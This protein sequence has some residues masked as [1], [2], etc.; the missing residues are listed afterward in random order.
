MKYEDRYQQY[1]RNN[2]IK[3]EAGIDFEKNYFIHLKVPSESKGKEIFYDV[4]V[5][6]F[7]PDEKI[8]KEITVE[9]YYV[10]FFS[11]SPGFIYKYA[12]LYKLQGYLIEFLTD[13]FV[14][15]ALD[16]LPDKANKTYD[17]YFDSTI[18]FACRYLLDHKATTLGKF[19]IRLMKTK[20]LNTFFQDIQDTDSI[21]TVREI[22]NLEASIRKEIRKDNKLSEQQE[23]KLKKNPVFAKEVISR[24]DA[25]RAKKSTFKDSSSESKTITGKQGGTKRIVASKKKRGTITTKKK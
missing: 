7:T 4:V 11:N 14:P 15:G 13:K 12:S 8:Q 5:Q 21:N 18:Y 19:S 25:K 6:F 20:N 2:K 17:L 10:Q 9:N 24:K 1:K 22:S 3:I 23:A 16:V